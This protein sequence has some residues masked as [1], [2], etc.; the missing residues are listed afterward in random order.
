LEGWEVRESQY[1]KSF[2]AWGEVK[3]ARAYLLR[4]LK[5]RLG[6]AAPEPIRLAIEGTN[7]LGILDRWFDAALAASSWADFQAAMQQS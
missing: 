4:A 2:E 5:S 3:Q 7:D 6:A 1:L